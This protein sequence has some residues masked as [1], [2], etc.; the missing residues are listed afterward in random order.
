MSKSDEPVTG[1]VSSASPA[2]RDWKPMKTAPKFRPILGWANGVWFS[3]QWRSDP[4]SLNAAI[5]KYLPGTPPL[6]ASPA[7]W[8]AYAYGM[9]CRKPDGTWFF[10][11]PSCWQELPPQPKDHTE[12]S[13]EQ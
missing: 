13:E 10:V 5:K 9:Y 7:G 11:E 1:S 8:C 2:G 6:E 3:M 4:T 12:Q